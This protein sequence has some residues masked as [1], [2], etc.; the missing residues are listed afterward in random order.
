VIRRALVSCADVVVVHW[1][2]GLAGLALLSYLG[3]GLVV[4]QRVA[5]GGTWFEAGEPAGLCARRGFVA[6]HWDRRQRTRPASGR[7]AI[8]VLTL[9]W[10]KG[11]GAAAAGCGR[12][13]LE[14][15]APATDWCS[16]LPGCGRRGRGQHPSGA[17]PS[18]VWPVRFADHRPGALRA[19]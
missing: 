16:V 15:R 13:T 2:G 11:E 3:L 17:V 9:T 12:G 1:V 14:A 5:G 19:R 10:L 18:F 6:I 8:G 4:H 7:V